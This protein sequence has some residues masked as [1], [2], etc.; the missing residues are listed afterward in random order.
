[1]EAADATVTPSAKPIP[2]VMTI[3]GTRSTE[4]EGSPAV[5]AGAVRVNRATGEA[6]SSGSGPDDPLTGSFG[7]DSVSETV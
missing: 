6:M 5:D 3:I 4:D 2:R 7:S 1:M